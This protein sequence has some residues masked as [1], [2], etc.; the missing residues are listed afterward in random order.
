[1]LHLSI[2]FVLYYSNG[3]HIPIS[4]TCSDQHAYPCSAGSDTHHIGL[5]ET[6]RVGD[7]D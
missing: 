6:C 5:E 2:M 1:M 4:R 3:L 7:I